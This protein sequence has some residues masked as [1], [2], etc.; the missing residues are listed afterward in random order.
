MKLLSKIL[1]IKLV[2]VKLKIFKNNF[3]PEHLSLSKML[4]FISAKLLI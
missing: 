2:K 1:N 4:F 3:K